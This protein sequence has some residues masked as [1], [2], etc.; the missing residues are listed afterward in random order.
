MLE[1]DLVGRMIRYHEEFGVTPSL[2]LCPSKVAP[3][4]LVLA[5]L[6]LEH[7]PHEDMPDYLFALRRKGERLVGEWR[8]RPHLLHREWPSLF[9][10]KDANGWKEKQAGEGYDMRVTENGLEE[11]TKGGEDG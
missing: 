6:G 7:A 9:F 5:R 3:H 8:G 2:I 1:A 4:I 10:R 11:I